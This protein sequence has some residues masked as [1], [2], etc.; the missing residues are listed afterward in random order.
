MFGGSDE[1]F[2]YNLPDSKEIDVAQIIMNNTGHPKLEDKL[3]MTHS[4]ILWVVSH[5]HL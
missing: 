3:S 5:I 1:D 4:G 2:L